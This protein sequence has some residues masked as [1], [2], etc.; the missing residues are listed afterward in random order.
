MKKLMIKKWLLMCDDSVIIINDI[1][2]DE[3]KW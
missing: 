2:N 1:D 3:M